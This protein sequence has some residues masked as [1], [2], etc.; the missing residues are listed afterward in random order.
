MTPLRIRRAWFPHESDRMA[1]SDYHDVVSPRG[2]PGR[3]AGRRSLSQ[4]VGLGSPQI[5]GSAG[6]RSFLRTIEDV[7]VVVKSVVVMSLL[8]LRVPGDKPSRAAARLHRENDPR[9]NFL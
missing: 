3:R 2:G 6:W 5:A 1:G 8:R 9:A 7:G 4:D